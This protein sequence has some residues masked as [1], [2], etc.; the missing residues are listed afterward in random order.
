M[1]FRTPAPPTAAR[2]QCAAVLTLLL[3]V[4]AATVLWSADSLYAPRR[5]TFARH[6]AAGAL[7]SNA[8]ADGMI[9][10]A[11]A[12]GSGQQDAAG[13]PYQAA[14]APDADALSGAA[15]RDRE[16]LLAALAPVQ[17]SLADPASLV[18]S[19]AGRRP[20]AAYTVAAGE[21]DGAPQQ[22]H[23][24][25]IDPADASLAVRP[26]LSFDRLFGYETLSV[27]AERAG[28]LAMV[29]GGF[30]WLDGR[31]SGTVLLDGV[32]WHGADERF[33]TLLIGASSASLVQLAT[34]VRVTA[35][36]AGLG[37]ASLNPW[38]MAPGL[39]VYTPAYGRTDRVEAGRFSITVSAGVVRQAGHTGEPAE[40]PADGFVLA[41]DEATAARIRSRCTPGTSVQWETHCSPALPGETL[42]GLSCGSWLVRDGVPCAPASDPWVGSLAGPAPR[43]A[44]GIGPEGQL[45]FVVAEG[46][47]AGGPSGLSGKTLAR[48]L[49]DMGLESAALLDGGASSGLIVGGSIQN[50]LS[51]GRER[52]LPDGF[53]LVPRQ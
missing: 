49:A 52:S 22:V 42:H 23:V 50:R 4:L 38:P 33:P 31:P 5:A 47:I 7:P 13:N 19:L 29:N 9:P 34:E 46:R 27:M 21:L 12:D 3:A 41:A 40:I 1:A 8:Q 10:A 32:F 37:T 24:L 16:A 25:S 26:V 30:S 18:P 43:T 17:A 2:P 35:G 28:A 44:V 51:A 48:L 14:E 53:A 39:S 20:G 15:V 45:V 6:Q 36:G 11:G